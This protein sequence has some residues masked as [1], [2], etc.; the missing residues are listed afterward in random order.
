MIYLDYCAHT[1]ASQRV[2]NTF[3]ECERN[4]TG[5]ANSNHSAGRKTARMIEETTEKIAELCGISPNEIIYT[6][7]ATEA[8]NLAVKGIAAS[9]RHVGKHI[10]S[11]ALEHSSISASLS[12]LMAS[13]YEIDLLRLDHNGRIDLEELEDLIRKDTCLVAVSACDSELGVIQPL[14]EI[15]KIV[16]RYPECRLH[17]DA[18]QAV[19]KIPFDFSIGDTVSFSPHKFFGLTGIG[20]LIRKEGVSLTPQIS[21]GASTTVYRS[22]TPAAG[23]I[24]SV[25]PALEDAI[26]DQKTNA[27]QVKLLHEYI[28][29]ALKENPGIS[30]N[31]TTF[32]I[33]HI[34]NLSIQGIKGSEA[35]RMLDEAG[36]AVSVKSACTADL[37]P[38]KSVLA[39]T[40]NRKRALESFRISLSHITAYEECDTLIHALRKITE[41][42][43]S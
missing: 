22:G 4:Y 1:P 38:S 25:L 17:I 19:G 27:G 40:G 13:G 37:L 12:A 21:G 15:E 16:R 29:A 32:S 6:S 18:T 2:L 24:A 30:V 41:R 43:G 23:L 35:Q 5:N 33:P 26:K 8:N 3:L 34:L 31:S 7:G 9:S 11:T 36:I 10:I 28:A 14:R 20:V 42:S 39:V